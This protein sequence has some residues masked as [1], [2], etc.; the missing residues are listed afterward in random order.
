MQGLWLVSYAVLWLFVLLEGAVIFVLLHELGN[1]ML[2]TAAGVSRDGLK[3]GRR[4]P[5]ITGL[6]HRGREIKLP[7][8]SGRHLLIVFASDDCQPC[9]KLFPHLN[10]FNRAMRRDLDVV[11]L[12]DADLERNRA[13][14]EA[15]DLDF[16]VVGSLEA[17]QQYA[18]RVTPFAT[19]VSPQGLIVGKGLVNDLGHLRSLWSHGTRYAVGGDWQSPD[20]ETTP[21]KDI[22]E[23]AHV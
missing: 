4:A 17:R 11:V 8:G 6:D 22:E 13:L 1:R 16:P 12:T 21:K 3:E 19:L 23:G 10:K 5:V 18:V 14:A 20:E 7:S 9:A 2:S 15:N